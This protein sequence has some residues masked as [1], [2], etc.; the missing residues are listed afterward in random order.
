MISLIDFILC[1]I[2]AIDLSIGGNIGFALFEAILG[3]TQVPHII[4]W[5]EKKFSEKER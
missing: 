3:A 2:L 5:L 1:V 4:R